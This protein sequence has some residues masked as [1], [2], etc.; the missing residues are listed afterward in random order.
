VSGL[1]IGYGDLVPK[2][3]LARVLSVSLG[4]SGILLAGLI[5]AVGVHAL[6]KALD[7]S[8]HG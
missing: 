5:V 7:S 3:P 8:H 2:S 4:L 6:H 1:T